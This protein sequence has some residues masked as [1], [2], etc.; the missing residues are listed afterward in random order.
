MDGWM[1]SSLGQYVS[2][3][4]STHCF[5]SKIVPEIVVLRI[6]QTEPFHGKIRKGL[7]V[8][9]YAFG[10]QGDSVSSPQYR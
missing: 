10:N 8:V 4:V 5:G 9:V 6:V 3:S 7:C 1:D 2:V